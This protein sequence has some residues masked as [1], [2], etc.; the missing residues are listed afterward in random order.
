MGTRALTFVY[1]ENNK[2]LVN[3]Y[4]Q[5]DGYTTGHGAELAE[6]LNGFKIINGIGAETTRV[7]NGMGCLAAQ[8]VAHF[9]DSVGQFYIHSVDSKE[10][11]QDYEYHVY[12]KDGE[13]RV[14]VTDRGCNMFG[15]T[16]SDVNES[17]FDGPV[18]DFVMFCSEDELA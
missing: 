3:L 12:Q 7:A 17:I 8:I 13:L 4:R 2:P 10:C 15:L 18:A 6:F 16:T 11:G 5:Y 1:S 9:K 14:A